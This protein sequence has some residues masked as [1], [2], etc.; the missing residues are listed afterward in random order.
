MAR[1]A[2]TA[3]ITERASELRIND[4]FVGGCSE[5]FRMTACEARTDQQSEE[6]SSSIQEH[7][8]NGRSTRF[9]ERLVKFVACGKQSAAQQSCAKNH[10]RFCVESWNAAKRSPQKKSQNRVFG[11]V[12]AFA[13]NDEN[14]P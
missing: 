5:F 3:A 1:H 10:Q 13:S 11:D 9:N 12:H 14:C 2:A 4:L 8:A 6:C 7:V